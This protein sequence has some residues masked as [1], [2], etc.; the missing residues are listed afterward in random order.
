MKSILFLTFL[1]MFACEGGGSSGGGGSS[2]PTSAPRNL[3]PISSLS[4]LAGDYNLAQTENICVNSGSQSASVVTSISGNDF[5][6]IEYGFTLPD[7]FGTVKYEISA[8]GVILLTGPNQLR[9]NKTSTFVKFSLSDYANEANSEATCGITDWFATEER[10]VT[11]TVCDFWDESVF[12]WSDVYVSNGTITYTNDKNETYTL[13]PFRK[14]SIYDVW[15][16]TDDSTFNVDLRDGE[17]NSEF[18]TVIK[19][20]LSQ[21]WLDVL[22]SAGRDTTGLTVGDV[23][24]CTVSIQIISLGPVF[25]DY[26]DIGYVKVNSE[27]TDTPHLNACLEQ[28]NDS[29][30]SGF[31]YDDDH[32]YYIFGNKLFVN[33]FGNSD[34]GSYISE[35]WR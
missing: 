4:E 13:H 17:A 19:S 3:E 21:D 22:N 11:N 23:F 16:K 2:S 5:K 25:Q 24:D 6:V 10:N 32:V 31:N 34:G 30:Q 9:I 14:K 20:T 29:S 12:S 33:Y 7:C 35:N 27:N 18:T 8:G 1:T 28:D 26:D 15:E